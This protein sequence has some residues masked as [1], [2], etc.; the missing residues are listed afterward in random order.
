MLDLEVQ[1]HCRKLENRNARAKTRG[2]PLTT[3]VLNGNEGR[4]GG[5]TSSKNLQQIYTEPPR[6]GSI[7]R[8]L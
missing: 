5:S 2:T 8:R 4:E 6:K 1:R 3:N 7:L